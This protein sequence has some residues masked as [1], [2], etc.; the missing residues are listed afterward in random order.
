VRGPLDIVFVEGWM[1]GFSPVADA[2]LHDAALAE[3]NR[4]LADYDRWHRL[5]DAFV[6]LRAADPAFVL[7]WRVEA[8]EA[9]KAAGRP[10]L[11]REAIEDYIRR[12]VPAYALYGGAPARIP[13]DRRLEIWLDVQRRAQSESS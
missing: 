4:A 3:P 5:L 2:A 10:G 13:N 8:E 11:S 6:S 7:R 9:M 12:F 1:L